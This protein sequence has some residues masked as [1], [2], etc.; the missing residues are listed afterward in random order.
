MALKRPTLIIAVPERDPTA[1]RR[2]ALVD[3]SGDIP[4]MSQ[5]RVW[6][7]WILAAAAARRFAII[8]LR[9]IDR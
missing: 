7:R 6:S 1:A 9:R 4:A 8:F 5:V 2:E 3:W